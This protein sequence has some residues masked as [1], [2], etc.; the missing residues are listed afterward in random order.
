MTRWV[1]PLFR[2]YA[3]AAY[4]V[5]REQHGLP[6]LQYNTAHISGGM[7]TMQTSPH[8]EPG[9]LANMPTVGHLALFNQ[10]LQKLGKSVEWN[11]IDEIDERVA[12]STRGTK[13]TP[14][15]FVTV[16]VD[17]VFYGSGRGTSK[18]AARN[19]AAKAG[20]DQLGIHVW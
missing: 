6:P 16:L 4:A 15:W 2:P 3:V 8:P 11:Y 5:A 10:H 20:L 1:I 13:A 19:E 12:P 14:L 9:E 17:G 18:K 7:I